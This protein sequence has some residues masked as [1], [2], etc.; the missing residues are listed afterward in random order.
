MIKYL[1]LLTGLL[2]TGCSLSNPFGI[3]HDESVCSE[4]KDF[5]MCGSPSV[6]YKYKENVKKVQNDYLKSRLDTTLYFGISE[7]GTIQ[8]KADRSGKWENYDTSEWK[9]LIDEKNKAQKVLMEKKDPTLRDANFD[10][11]SDIPVT[12]GGDLSV[13]YT[14]QAKQVI[15]RTK[16]GDIIRDQGLIQQVFISN[17]ID[18]DNDLIAAH[19]VYVVVREP[20]WKVGE[21][22]PKNVKLESLS[23]P[24]SSKLLEKQQRTEAYQEKVV[25]K[26]NSSAV[27]GFSEIK[28]EPSI[29]EQNLINDFIKGE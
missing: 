26:Y 12:K 29:K 21:Q 24:M 23:T 15:T 3:G 5:G 27:E 6:I 16:I 25:G 17:Y 1:I 22:T 14:E 19:E 9:V 18:N 10:I 13:S 8:V 2:F 11:N 7:E 28:E 20:N 4:S